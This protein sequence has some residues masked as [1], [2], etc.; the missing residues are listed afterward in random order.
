MSPA[1]PVVTP[2]A[3]VAGSVP[4]VP[5]GPR[6]SAAKAWMPGPT[7]GM[8]GAGVRPGKTAEG[9]TAGLVLATHVFA[10]SARS[11]GAEARAKPGHDRASGGE[12]PRSR[13]KVAS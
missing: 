8:T 10:T 11:K 13:G 6:P 9:V 4:A 3:V 12:G 5:A 1:C 2:S 7:P